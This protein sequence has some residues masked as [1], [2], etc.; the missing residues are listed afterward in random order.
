[1][2]QT[3]FWGSSAIN[4]YFALITAWVGRVCD[5]FKL[6]SSPVDPVFVTSWYYICK[7]FQY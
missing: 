7:G 3:V 5:N 4:G 6:P 1:M 2:G